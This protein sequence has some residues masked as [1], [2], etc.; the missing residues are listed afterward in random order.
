MTIAMTLNNNKFV[1]KFLWRDYY[2]ILHTL[3]S[4]YDAVSIDVFWASPESP[5][6]LPT[7]NN[8]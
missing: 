8:K 6:C 4:L 2:S 1:A 3:I 7:K 5:F